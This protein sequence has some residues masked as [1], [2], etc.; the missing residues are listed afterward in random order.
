MPTLTRLLFRLAI[1]ALLIYGAMLALVTFVTPKQTEMSI[2]IPADRLNPPKPAATPAVNPA[3][4]N[5]AG[6]PDGET[7]S[8]APAQPVRP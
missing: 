2:R 8:D 6:P 7:P 3:L 5:P 4:P 1:A